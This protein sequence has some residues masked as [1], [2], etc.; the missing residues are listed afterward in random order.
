M[1]RW[2]QARIQHIIAG[3]I[4]IGILAW[5]IRRPARALIAL[6]VFLPFQLVG[7]PFLMRFHVPIPVLRQAG[8]LKELLGVGIL[9]AGLHAIR[10]EKRQLD[11]IDKA[12]IVYVAV[13][14]LYLLFPH[15]FAARPPR[16]WNPRLLAWR[17]DCGYVLLFFGVRHAPISASARR[18]FVRV[19]LLI[20]AVT[21]AVAVYQWFQPHAFEHWMLYSDRQWLYQ[22]KVLGADPSKAAEVFNRLYS[23]NPLRISS[24]LLSPFDMSDFLLLPVAIAIERIARQDRSRWSYLLC[25]GVVFALFASRV[26]ADGVAVMV[27]FLVA[28]VPSPTRPTAARWR[29]LA[30][31]CAGA[32]LV[33]PSLGGTRFTNAEGG[34]ASNQ[35]HV[36]ELQTGFNQLVH[37]PFGA[38]LGTIPG[39]GDRYLLRAHDQG[40]FSHDN[41]LLQVG[42]ELGLQALLPYLVLLVLVWR[43]LSRSARRGG[44]FEGGVRLALLGMLVAGM[45]HHVFLSYPV[46]WTL[47]AAV[48]LAIGSSSRTA[49]PSEEQPGSTIGLTLPGVRTV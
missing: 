2:P 45:Y 23:F 46:P 18:L 26:R 40:Q 37:H 20:A 21:V 48:G 38:G 49:A 4:A 6:I 3:V 28:L 7:V 25:A 11:G 29:L 16:Q 33:V 31:V 15:V 14:T 35:S 30:A 41:S 1:T 24:I 8:G 27:I 13:V 43:G 42:D 34:K 44:P 10:T 22:V 9:I 32:L 39:V 12:V 47:W 5:A 17:A 19:V 36:T